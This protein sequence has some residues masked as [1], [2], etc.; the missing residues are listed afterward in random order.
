MNNKERLTTL[1]KFQVTEKNEPALREHK[2]FLAWIDKVAPLLK[3][4]TNH[5]NIFLN[6]AQTASTHGLSSHTI[7]QYFNIAK[8]TLN[9]A[10]Y[11]LEQGITETEP[12]QQTSKKKI[13]NKGPNWHDKPFGKIVIAVIA[14]IIL[15]IIKFMIGQFL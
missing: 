9:Q 10:I 2:V 6:A 3:Y 5:Y 12:T 13:S 1:K 14:G 15:L 11:E 4:D 8:S 7:T